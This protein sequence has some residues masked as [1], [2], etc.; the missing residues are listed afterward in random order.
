MSAR[1]T[2]WL[3]SIIIACITLDNMQAMQIWRAFHGHISLEDYISFAGSQ[4]KHTATQHAAA[5]LPNV[6]R[7]VIW[8]LILSVCL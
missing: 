3:H 1:Y 6:L 4:S 5:V 7:I 8:Q 2:G